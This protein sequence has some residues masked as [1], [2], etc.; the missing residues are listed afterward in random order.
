MTHYVLDAKIAWNRTVVF[1]HDS[2]IDA[3]IDTI[4]LVM[5]HQADRSN[6]CRVLGSFFNKDPIDI[7]VIRIVLFGAK[8]L[9]V[10]VGIKIVV[11]DIIEKAVTVLNEFRRGNGSIFFEN[12]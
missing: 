2:P 7:Y 12:K 9:R 5:F 10:H 1:F 4:L 3:Q 11:L 8:S 6:C